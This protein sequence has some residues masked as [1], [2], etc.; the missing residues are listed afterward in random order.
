M[1]PESLRLKKKVRRRETMNKK[2]LLSLI[3]TICMVMSMTTTIAYGSVEGAP[4]TVTTV[5][6]SVDATSITVE[7]FV[8]LRDGET[9]ED[10]SPLRITIISPENVTVST[11]ET[12][13]TDA[14]EEAK[15]R[16][17]EWLEMTR[18]EN[19]DKLYTVV[20][21]ITVEGDKVSFDNRTY[22]MRTAKSGIVIEETTSRYL[23]IEGDYG[24]TGS[25]TVTLTV[26]TQDVGETD[27]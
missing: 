23:E 15:T 16:L 17:N 14:I 27:T 26:E 12:A 5:D 19:P 22:T 2:K 4:V 13:K 8:I 25:Y 1:C 10:A 9:K 3:L 7:A 21:E 24:H 6:N 11:F 20:G 18:E